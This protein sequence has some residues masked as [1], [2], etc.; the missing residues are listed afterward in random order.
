MRRAVL[1]V[2]ALLALLE[3]GCSRYPAAADFTLT[4][5]HG[6]PWALSAQHGKA[7]ALF[8][9]FTHCVD[10]CPTTLA[11]LGKAAGS[12]PNVVI[13]FVTVDP[14]RDTPAVLDAYLKRFAPAPIVGLTGTPAQIA[15]VERAYHV[16]SQKIPGK[17]GSYDYDEAHIATVFF[18]DQRGGQRAIA[19]QT[20]SVQTLASDM[21]TALQ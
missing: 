3:A 12:D 19:D 16:W 21:H 11:K 8:F 6:R 18:I 14:Q 17:R 15:S 7:V 9:G 2:A 5:N 1:V 20:D 4:D 10:T 13:A